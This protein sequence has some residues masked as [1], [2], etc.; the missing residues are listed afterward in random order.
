VI[1]AAMALTGAAQASH[2]DG[3]G[4]C[5]NVYWGTLFY[6]QGNV[7]IFENDNQFTDKIQFLGC[8][9]PTGKRLVLANEP[10]GLSASG[11]VV[12]DFTGE[13]GYGPWVVWDS[14]ANPPG[15]AP[16]LSEV[17]VTARS[18]NIR[19][20]QFGP[21]VSVTLGVSNTPT[22]GPAPV[23]VTGDNK[24]LTLA[25]VTSNGWYAWLSLDSAPP[26]DP[27]AADALYIPDG[28]GGDVRVASAPWKLCRHPCPNVGLSDLTAHGTTISWIDDGVRNSLKLGPNSPA[29]AGVSGPTGTTGT[30]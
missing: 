8:W 25:V 17:T 21:V 9:I 19:T 28:K 10:R 20:G 2:T 29:L 5:S 6:R 26:N 4:R 15:S 23:D 3:L 1:L 16:P 11:D 12:A 14:Q 13:A 27:D 24:R 30:S 22:D 7:A 18:R